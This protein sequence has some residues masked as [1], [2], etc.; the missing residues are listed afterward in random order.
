MGDALLFIRPLPCTQIL[1]D[2]AAEAVNVPGFL[3]WGFYM[4]AKA[5]AGMKLVQQAHILLKCKQI[6]C[7]KLVHQTIM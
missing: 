7:R 2:F 4:Q 6:N 3:E 5:P 1:L